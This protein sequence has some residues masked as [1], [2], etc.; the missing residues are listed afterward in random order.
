MLLALQKTTLDLSVI[1]DH[2]ILLR[3]LAI[4]K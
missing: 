4:G 2:R 3:L 1:Q